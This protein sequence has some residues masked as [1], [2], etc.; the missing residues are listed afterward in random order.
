MIYLIL[1]REKLR[2]KKILIK[3]ILINRR[4]ERRRE[5]ELKNLTESSSRIWMDNKSIINNHK[6]DWLE[7]KRKKEREK[8]SNKLSN[9]NW[10]NRKKKSKNN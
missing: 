6:M 2:R 9:K 4:D 8:N 7:I 3:S 1:N 10:S 5:N